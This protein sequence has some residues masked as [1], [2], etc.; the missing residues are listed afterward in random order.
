MSCRKWIDIYEEVQKM[1]D[2]EHLSK[3]DK[4]VFENTPSP[5]KMPADVVFRQTVDL[6]LSLNKDLFV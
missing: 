5:C 4:F 2:A 6:M 3:L 1:G